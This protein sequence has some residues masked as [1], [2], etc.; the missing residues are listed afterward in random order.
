MFPD[1]DARDPGIQSTSAT[2]ECE[3]GQI[4]TVDTLD[5]KEHQ[6]ALGHPV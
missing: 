5:G 2:G 6:V 1:S 3:P 4:D